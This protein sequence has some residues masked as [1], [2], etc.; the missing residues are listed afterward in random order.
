M[1]TFPRYCRVYDKP[2]W[3]RYEHSAERVEQGLGVETY[4]Y[5]YLYKQQEVPQHFEDAENK[6]GIQFVKKLID[7]SNHASEAVR[8]AVNEL[9]DQYSYNIQESYYEFLDAMGWKVENGKIVNKDGSKELDFKEYYNKLAAEAQRLGMD[10]NFMDYIIPTSSGSP[11]M[12]NFM[13]LVATKFENIIQSLFN[14]YITRQT[15]L[16]W[17]GAQITNVGYDKNL[18]YHPEVYFKNGT[19]KNPISKEEYNKLSEE[20]KK[21][22]YK[23]AYAEVM[24]PRWSK[25]IPKDMTIEELEEAGLDIQLGY[26][27]PTEGK[28]SVTILKV[29]GFLDDSQGSTIMVPNDWVTQTGADFDV[30]SIYGICY[31]FRF[32]KRTRKFEKIEYDSDTS[33]EAVRKRYL[34]LVRRKIQVDYEGITDESFKERVARYK[35]QFET[36]SPTAGIKEEIQ[37]LMD[38]TS[39]LLKSYPDTIAKAIKDFT[40][41]RKGRPLFETNELLI[42][43]LE[44]KIL[45]IIKNNELVSNAIK[46]H[47]EILK[48]I[49]NL[50][51]SITSESVKDYYK[52]KYDG[53][54]EELLKEAKEK[55]FNKIQ[56]AAKNLGF[57]SYEE[58]AKLPIS[59]QNSR[60][61]RDNKI[62]DSWLNILQD[63]TSREENYSRSNFDDILDAKRFTEN[64]LGENKIKRSAYN[65]LDQIQF[66]VNAMATRELKARSVIRDNFL[67]LCNKMEMIIDDNYSIDVRYNLD[68]EYKDEDGNVHKMYD[69]E[70]IE[71]CYGED[72]LSRDGNILTIK[73]N[74]FG[75]SKTDRNITGKLLTAYSSQTTAHIL[76]AIKEGSLKNENTYTFGVFKTLI[77]LGIDYFTALTFLSQK[78][79]TEIVKANAETSSVIQAI[80]AYPVNMA[81]KQILKQA[82]FEISTYAKNKEIITFIT[83]SLEF[84]DKFKEIYGSDL[85]S[86]INEKGEL[87]LYNLPIIFDQ[88]IL[89]QNLK[90]PNWCVDIIVALQFGKLLKFTNSINNSL[91]ELTK[92]SNPDKFGAKQSIY[93]TK[94]IKKKIEKLRDSTLLTDKDGVTFINKLYPLD[95][96]G[97][98]D[99][100]KSGYKYLAAFLKYATLP[101]IEI[102]QQ[103][104]KLEQER[105]VT[106]NELISDVLGRELTTEQHERLNK[107]IVNYAFNNVPYLQLPLTIDEKGFIGIDMSRVVET[108]TYNGVINKE[109][110]RIQGFG[111]DNNYIT[112]KN[113]NKPTKEEI[114]SFN[115]L[116]P[117]EKVI[118]IQQNFKSSGIFNT[119]FIETIEGKDNT[120]KGKSSLIKYTDNSQNQETLYKL[121]RESFSNKNP[122]I[123]L[124]AIDL[125]KY[126]FVVEGYEF[127]KGN[128]S[129]LIVNSAILNR[130]EDGGL[131]LIQVVDEIFNI[132]ATETLASDRFINKFIRANSDLVKK[133][134]IEKP[135]K[136]V[137]NKEFTPNV[138][139]KLDSL[140]ENKGNNDYFAIA[141]N[142][143]NLELLRAL[144]VL[145]NDDEVTNL[146]YINLT[147]YAGKSK[148]YKTTLYRIYY[149]KGVFAFVP[150]N[151]LEKFETSDYSIN[152]Y[153]NIYAREEYYYKTFNEFAEAGEV[154]QIPNLKSEIPS[155]GIKNEADILFNQY[156]LET[157]LSTD[158]VN[159]RGGA[160]KLVQ[161]IIDYINSPVEGRPAYKLVLLNNEKFAKLNI[162]KDCRQFVKTGKRSKTQTSDITINKIKYGDKRGK[163]IYKLLKDSN[164]RDILV[165][166]KLFTEPRYEDGTSVNTKSGLYKLLTSFGQYASAEQEAIKEAIQ[167]L[168]VADKMEFK[169]LTFYRLE[170]T[171]IEPETKGERFSTIELAL[172]EEFVDETV[173]T[174]AKKLALSMHSDIQ[175]RATNDDVD[176]QKYV[177]SMIHQAIKP[178]IDVSLEEGLTD[179]YK[180]AIK[181]YESLAKR[182]L[183][184]IEQFRTQDG[185]VYDISNINLYNYLIESENET[186]L[187]NLIKLILDCKTFGNN[188]DLVYS[189]NIK[190]ENEEI[191]KVINK[192]IKII[193]DVKNNT[194]INYANDTLFNKY[195]ASKQSTNP[196]VKLGIVKLTDVFDDT[197]WF[198]LNI[199]DIGDLPHKQ[200]QNIVSYV[201]NKLDM[202]KLTINDSVNAFLK[203]YDELLNMDGEFR[204]D[205]VFNE[206]GK[207]GVTYTEEFFEKKQEFADK[208]NEYR[209]KYGELSVEYQKLRL[210]KL[211]WYA[212]NVEQELIK[213]YYDEINQNLEYILNLAPDIYLE[214]LRLNRKITQLKKDYTRLTREQRLELIKLNKQIKLLCDP[215]TVKFE[216]E[217]VFDEVHG[218]KFIEKDTDADKLYAN[219]LALQEF[220]AKQKEINKKYFEQIEDVDFKETL[221][222]KLEIIKKYD[223]KYPNDRLFEKLEH[224]EY[225]DAYDW[226]QFNTYYRVSDETSLAIRKAFNTL[227]VTDGTL[228]NRQSLTANKEINQ[229]IEKAEK[230]R[231]GQIKDEYGIFHPENLTT[232]EIRQIKEITERIYI[233]KKKASAEGLENEVSAV[234]IKSIPKHQ[235]VYKRSVYNIFKKNSRTREENIRQSEIVAE[236]NDIIKN[237]INPNTGNIS[238]KLLFENCTEEQLRTLASLYEE[239]KEIYED[240]AKGHD[241]SYAT[242][243]R[244]HRYEQTGLFIATKP[245]ME[246][247]NEEKAYYLTHLQNTA[248]GTLW[249]NIFTEDGNVEHP[250][251]DMFGYFFVTKASGSVVTREE[252]KILID[253]EKTAAKEFIEENIEYVETEAYEIEW[254]RAVAEDRFKEWF[255]ENHYYDPFTHKISPLKIWT[256]L[257]IK[258]SSALAK[259]TRVA[260]DKNLNK[261]V[262]DN[263]FL[264]NNYHKGITTYKN[265]TGEYSNG[266][267]Y[268]PKELEIIKFLRE[269][270]YKY[271]ATQQTKDFITK[272]YIPRRRKAPE[273]DA[274]WLAKQVLGSVGLQADYQERDWYDDISYTRDKEIDF[275]MAHLLKGV[276][277]QELEKVPVHDDFYEVGSPEWNAIETE[278]KEVKERNK[279][280]RENNLRIDRELMDR[281]IK[282]IMTDYISKSIIISAKNE[283]K[284]AI[285]LMQEDLKNRQAYLKSRYTNNLV[286]NKHLSTDIENEYKTIAQQNTLELFTNWARRFVYDQYKKGSKYEQIAALLQNIT[287][288]KYMI[289][290]VTGGVANVLTGL[291]N[292][293][294]ETFARD[295][296]DPKDFAE[297]QARYFASLPSTL[298]TMYSNEA[299]DINSAL[300]KLYDV[301]NYEAMLERREGEKL[302]EYADRFQNLLYGLQTGGEHYMQNLVLLA[303]LMSH[304]LVKDSKGKYHVMS[305]QQYI[306]DVEYRALKEAIKDNPDLITRYNKEIVIIQRDA[307]KRMKYDELRNNFVT[308]FIKGYTLE[309]NNKELLNK[310][311]EIKKEMMRTAKSEFES[312][313]RAIDQYEL[314]NGFAVL[315]DGSNFTDEM[316]A[317]LKN[318]VVQINKEIHGVYDKIGAAKIE[319][320]WWGSLVMQYHKHLYPGFMKRYRVKGYYNELKDSFE[321]GSY[322]S[323]LNFMLTEYK[324]IKE[325]V[326]K[327]KEEGENLIVASMFEFCKATIDT[328]TNLTLNWEMLPEWEKNNIRKTYGD[329]CGIA[330]SMLIAIGLHMATEDDDL[331]N[332]NTLSTI[333]YLADRL[334]SETRLYTPAGL[335]VETETLMSSPLAATSSVEDLLKATNIIFNI[336]FDEDYNPEYTTGLYRGEHRLMVLL[337][338]NIPGYRVYNRLQNMSKNNQYYR[339]NDN[340][341]NIKVAK[342]IANLIVEED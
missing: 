17:H 288:A 60:K 150:L 172:D 91:E 228:P 111:L 333:L 293:L 322:M 28:Q 215:L 63:I 268:S 86:Y 223:E 1:H 319:A 272:G 57:I 108:D 37:S 278:I 119:L 32:N 98:I 104:F 96:N 283:S 227:S 180:A 42:Q 68:N 45:P 190:G 18:R 129:K 340:S 117:V 34:N 231:P 297:A 273:T 79:I 132:L 315:K 265:D 181:Y 195:F 187:N 136:K 80:S 146:Q 9:M 39:E 250:N 337:K 282:N 149:K 248:L 320:E 74:K 218:F 286:E 148:G 311:L 312:N 317:E 239:L 75:W 175:V 52:Q 325:R 182:L 205:V 26:R 306:N 296:F 328:V 114:E 113:P 138:G 211:K 69:S 179:I 295:Y 266:I 163:I 21:G 229:I 341:R 53:V 299:N 24:I 143:E 147:R 314:S 16:G 224:E 109:R 73:H 342:N 4:Y 81:I 126:A 274:K 210:E 263:S 270:L 101:S 10:S 144:R 298:S 247:Y 222:K 122:L 41:R 77:D 242:R 220:R 327:D 260:V 255:E 186:D 15:I 84:R 235:P 14:N 289:F 243:T 214:Y 167:L 35:K 127:R 271:A 27:V 236:I 151:K 200:V 249:R 207:L 140:L 280:I 212:K 61:A 94:Q 253:E 152:D 216:D 309:S 275:D 198:N 206:N 7:N 55:Y 71:E 156:G 141:H 318:K 188:L 316:Y 159:L 66:Y 95:E 201:Y 154:K 307:N 197:S 12:P 199:G 183:Q 22:Y 165:D 230:E 310:Y 23:A 290:N 46:N 120:I 87:D 5:K 226:I 281:N 19:T 157:L 11:A 3:R 245:N 137:K 130:I 6:V 142:E 56:K 145:N 334:F 173:I 125:I 174:K 124:A 213:D 76:D 54:R 50:I 166:D 234:L 82:G 178:K 115:K 202:A 25:N 2:C 97:E 135:A 304:R 209:V 92:I 277:Y 40:F 291:T 233:G 89:I 303:V 221:E 93:E 58:F 155:K 264:N 269:Q 161:A 105:F 252:S 118:Y 121:F 31:H 112:I 196:L 176:A 90:N 170:E 30:D 64:L 43:Y 83:K 191:S 241:V 65:P 67:S 254:R 192:L 267:V 36:E 294:G 128:V 49:N 244:A 29:V 134:K 106:I 332:S 47:I 302:H 258:E 194:K 164:I 123:R 208:L 20:E 324:N 44:S 326:K 259:G 285:Y 177:E 331:K 330:A 51:T 88:N 72:I 238:T 203:R 139:N 338:R 204:E 168:K 33:E 133:V 62:I 240:N 313:A 158:N 193:N 103:V 38:E 169:N 308:D 162:P 225:R 100:E 301:V 78:G 185:G 189:L 279:K 323:T 336:A 153:N 276:G 160:N 232:D 300:Y 131:N 102:N 246:A 99:V 184:Q 251:L 256:E 284:N 13:N 262:K 261:T 107:Y 287:S 116:S 110:F 305:Y 292:I 8:N 219:K 217:T 171:K 257:R 59:L 321:K 329:L 335:L 237:A 339:I 48:T 70:I 85:E